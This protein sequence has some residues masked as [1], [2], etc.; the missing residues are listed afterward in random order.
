MLENK[1]YH[2][3]KLILF[4]GYGQAGPLLIHIKHDMERV[5]KQRTETR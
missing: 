4:S 3:E 2:K 5:Q 1:I